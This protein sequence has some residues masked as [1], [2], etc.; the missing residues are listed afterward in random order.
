M[1][2]GTEETG[3]TIDELVGAGIRRDGTLELDTARFEPRKV[4][5]HVGAVEGLAHVYTFLNQGAGGVHPLN[6]V[7]ASR[8]AAASGAVSCRDQ[9]GRWLTSTRLVPVRSVV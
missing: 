7:A 1:A 6:Q 4:V 3:E 8:T 2:R 9:L 5:A